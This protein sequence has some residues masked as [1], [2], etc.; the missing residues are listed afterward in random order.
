MLQPKYFPNF[1]TGA[2]QVY[3]ACCNLNI[4]LIS[5]QGL[6]K[7]ILNDDSTAMANRGN[8]NLDNDNN[9]LTISVSFSLD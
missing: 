8:L 1:R 5:G 9:V 4:F 7:F 3:S 6:D 2:G